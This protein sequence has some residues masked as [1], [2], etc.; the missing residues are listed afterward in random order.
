[1]S[2]QQWLKSGSIKVKAPATPGLSDPSK[3]STQRDVLVTQAA[4]DG[5]DTMNS[6][7]SLPTTPTRKRKRGDYNFYDDETWAKIA[8]Y[9]VENGVARAA[10]KLSSDLGKKVNETSVRS[11]RDTYL[12]FKKQGGGDID[13]LPRSPRGNP[14]LLGHLDNDVQQCILSVRKNGGVINSRIVMAAAEAV[15]TKFARHKL[16]KYG[17]H[18]NI[19]KTYAISVLRR[20]GV[21]KRKGTKGV[22]HLPADFDDIKQEY[23]KKV[24]TVIKQHSIPDSL[25]IKWDQTGCQLIPGGDWTMEQQGSQQVPITGIDDKRQITLLL[26]TSM[27]GSLLPPQLIYQGKTDRS[28][29]KGVDFPDNWDVT[30]TET[31]W[32]NENTMIR[33]VDKVILPYVEGIIEDL[34]LSQKNQKA[35]GILDVYRAHT[36][37]KLLR[38][39][40]KNDIIPLF[41]SAACTDK[42]QPLDLSVNREYKEQLKSNFHD[43][44]SAQVVQQLNHQEDITG[45]RAPKVIV[46][47][48]TSVMKP[49]HA[50]WIV[51]THQ[52]MSNRTDLI[53]SGFRKAGLL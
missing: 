22:K 33:F 48:K 5:I 10:R 16:Q 2:L 26:A 31:R 25:V 44:Y 29:P 13:V 17:G 37:E 4:N 23:V 18:I 20:I 52:I 43:W 6:A 36:G 32:S 1:M 8:R 30:S 28:L 24:S 53:K 19:T 9:S 42:L 35:V 7:T 27:N 34:P 47:L 39:L 49:A 3:C 51:S 45:E 38:H 12:K 41:V 15:V 11:M 46:D 50:Q 14:L 21:V 40:K